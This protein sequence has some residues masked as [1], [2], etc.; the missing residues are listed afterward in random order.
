MKT[1]ILAAAL[2]SGCINANTPPPEPQVAVPPET[3]RAT[4]LCVG[5]ETS[6]RFGACP[7]CKKDAEILS[8]LMNAKLGYSGEVLISEKATKAAVVKKLKEG[9]AATPK[10]GLFLFFYSG[11]GGQE[12]L[13][14]QEPTGADQPDEYLCLYDAHLLDDEIWDLVS[15]CRGRVFLYFDACHSA[16]MYRSVLSD[17]RVKAKGPNTAVALGVS[18]KDMV[19]SKGFA[20]HPERFVT[21]SAL[22]TGK[23]AVRLLCW[24]GCKEAEFSYGGSGGGVL[25]LSV[26][27]NWKPG[28]TYGTLWDAALRRVQVQQPGQNPVQTF[29]G[30]GFTTSMEAFK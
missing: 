15:T 17:L 20:F 30:G 26:V 27:G 21:G 23:N 10:D 5:M 2:I 3:T 1:L 19:K 14:G 18:E 28:C 6:A 8:A 22:S 7:G 12:Y 29:V 9:L 24:S 16:T 13:G 11:H 4:Y 25:T